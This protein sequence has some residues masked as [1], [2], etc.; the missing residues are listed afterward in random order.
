MN[1]ILY[2][3]L[4]YIILYCL[5]LFFSLVFVFYCF[6]L[7]RIDVGVRV[8]VSIHAVRAYVARAMTI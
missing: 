2:Y 8:T 7:L 1:I 5:Y 4:Y 3:I 6:A